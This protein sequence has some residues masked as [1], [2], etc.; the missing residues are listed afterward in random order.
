MIMKI[1]KFNEGIRKDL[2][3]SVIEDVMYILSPLTDNG[4]QITEKTR[5]NSF[6]RI[7]LSV[8]DEDVESYGETF[9]NIYLDM[10][11]D[12]DESYNIQKLKKI[13]VFNNFIGIINENIEEVKDRLD[14]L[15]KN[16]SIRV[17]DFLISPKTLTI[18]ISMVIKEKRKKI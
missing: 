5:Q 13:E 12:A 9:R 16:N 15:V 14:E 11:K 3:S 8:P 18:F 1:L 7:G 6:F 2:Y 4:F 10:G 17:E